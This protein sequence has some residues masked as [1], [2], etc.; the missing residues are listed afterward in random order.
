MAIDSPLAAARQRAIVQTNKHSH[1]RIALEPRILFDGAAIATAVAQLFPAPAEHANDAQSTDADKPA[2]DSHAAAPNEGTAPE[3]S[4]HPALADASAETTPDAAPDAASHAGGSF[5]FID[6]TLAHRADLIAAAPAGAQVVLIDPASNGLAQIDAALA[7]HDNVAAIHIISHGSSGELQIGSTTLNTAAI[8]ADDQHLLAA[9]GQHL[10]PGADVLVYG[11]DFGAGEEGAAATEALAHALH[12]DVAS[13][14]DATGASHLGGDW[15]LERH[16]GAIQ[17]QAIDAAGWDG[18]FLNHAPVAVADTALVNA[19]ISSTINVLA[20]DTDVDGDALTVTTA[21]AMHGTVVINGNG[22]LTYTPTA[23]YQGVDT[24]TYTIKD[25]NNAAALL[26]GTVAVTVNAAP[27]LTLPTLS[28]FNEDVSKVF[29]SALGTQISVSDADGSIARVSLSVPNGTLSLSQTTGLA[30]TLGTGSN[31]SAV[32]FQG[33]ITNVNAALNGMVFAPGAD[34]NGSMSLSASVTDNIVLTAVS[35]TVA[36]SVTAVAD[37]VADSVAT[38][39]GQNVSFNVLTNDTFEN[40]GRVVSSVGTASHGTVS[41]SAQ[42]AA[43]YTPTAGY[44]GTDSFTYTVTTNGTT[45]TATVTVTISPPA[46]NA[47]TASTISNV[48]ASDAQAVSINVSSAFSDADAD[49][50]SYSAT[51]LPSGVS[52]NASTGVISGTLGGHASTAVAGG[53][54]TVVVTANDGRGGTVNQSFHLVV[55]DPAPIANADSGSVVTGS[56]LTGNVLTNDTDPDGDSLSILTTPVVMPSHG[57]LVLSVN[58]NYSYTPTLNYTGTDSFTYRVTDVDGG[59]S[60]AVVSLVISAANHAPVAV[61]DTAFVNA[62]GSVVINVLANDTDADG[63]ALTVTSASALH[64]TVAINGNGTLL[65]TPTASYSGADVI[66][67]AIQDAYGL[68]AGLSGTVAVTVNASA[69]ISLPS[70]PVFYEDVPLIFASAYGTQITVGDVDGNIARVTLSVPVGNLTLSQTTGLTLSQGTGTNDST[71]TLQGSIANVNTALNGL[72]YTPGADY[73]GAVTITLGLTDTLMAVPVTTSL[74]LTI[75]AVADI[76]GDSVSTTLGQSITFNVL[77]NDT[78]ENSGRVV[79]GYT[80]PS[81]GSVS[82]N[83]QGQASYTPTT[84]YTGTDAF[85]YTVTSNGTTE[86]ATVSITIGAAPNQAP[87]ASTI[88]SVAANDAQAV[89]INVSGAFNDADG[90]SLSFSATGL[91]SGLSINASTGV[92]TGTLSG[93]AST[94]VAGGDYTVI[95][96]ASDGRGGSVSQSF[97]LVAA[98]PGPVANA[99]SAAGINTAVLYGNVLTN[100]TDADGDTLT[101][102]TTP[103]VAPAHGSVVISANG[104]YSYTPTLNYTGTDSFTYRVTDADGGTATGTVSIV[105]TAP[106]NQLPTAVADTAFVNAGSSVIINVLANDTD[107]D[108]EALSITH[109]SAAHG[110]VTTNPDGTLTYTPTVGY[111]GT[112]V[113]TYGIQDPRGGNALVDGSVAVTINAL[114]TLHLPTL[115]VL[116]EDTPI[117]FA[118]VLGTQITVGDIDGSVAEVTLSVPAGRLTLSQTTGLSFS[119]GTGTNDTTVTFL[120][121]IVNVNAALNGLVYTPGADYNGP[122]TLTISLTDTLLVIPIT[123]QLPLNITAVVDIVADSVATTTGQLVAFNVLAN[124]N[125]E[126]SG[127]VVSGYTTPSHG[128]VT[129]T[130]QGAASYTPTSGYT[131]TDSFTYT[132]TSNSTTET[133]TVTIV[134]GTP[135][136]NAPTA[137]TL[138]N[139]AASDAQTIS[140]AT[141]STFSDADGDALAYSASGLPTGLSIHAATGVI[142]GQIDGHASTVNGGAYT[143]VVTA[144]DGRGGSVSRSFVINVSNPAPTATDDSATLAEDGS[145]SGNILTND[146]DADG[147]ALSV[148]TTP[149]V[150]PAHG[151]LT[152]NANG[153]YV[154]TPHANFFGSDSFTYRVTD[155]DGASATAVVYLTVTAINDAPTSTAIADRSNTVGS[156]V[157]VNEASAFSDVDGDA[158]VY[159][160]TGLPTGLSVNASTGLI[161][162]TLL[163]AGSYTVTLRA[164]DTGGLTTTQSFHWTVAAAPNNAPN[165]VGSLSPSSANDGAAV[166]IATATAFSDPDGDPLSFSA[167]GLPAGLSINAVTGLISGT[168]NGH[169]S[170]AV[171]GGVYTVVVTANDARGGTVAQVF[172]FT[173]SNPAPTAVADGGAGVEDAVIAGNV[174]T[175]DSDADGDALAV[176]TAPLTAP[177]HG[178]VVLSANG[179]FTYTP[180]SNYSGSDSFTYQV[181]DAD[182]GTSTATVTLT[183]AAVNDAPT[184]TALVDRS[185]TVGAS[186]SVSPSA[187]FIDVDGDALIFT[188]T[189]LPPGLTV[190]ASTGVISGTLRTVGSYSVTLTATDS[191]GLSTS[192]SFYWTAAAAPNNGP[193]T[194]GTLSASTGNDG[195]AVAISTSSAFSDPDGDTLTF[196][197]SGLPAGLTINASTGVISGT[198]DGHASTATSGGVY[199]VIVTANDGRGGSASQGF[200]F[201]ASNPGPTASADSAAGIEDNAISGNVLSNDSDADSDALAVSTTPIVAPSH[202]SLVLSANGAFTYTPDPNYSGSDSFTYQVTDADGGTSTATL[203]LTIAAINDAPTSTALVDRSNTVGASV[204]VSPS[205]SFTDVDGDALVYTATGLPPGLTV[206][207]STGVIS[208]TLLTVGSYSVTLTATDSGGLSTSQSFNWTAAAAPNNGPNTVGVLSA[209][210]GNDGAAVAINTSSAFSDPD[211]DTLTFSATGLPAGLSITANTGVISGTVDGHASTATSGGVYTVIVTANDGRGGSASQGFTFTASNPA[212]TASADSAT[213]IEDNAIS[214]NVLSNDSDADGDALAVSTTPVMA[215]LH[216]SVVLSANGAFTYTPDSNYAGS[217]S[218]TYQ[219]TDADGS[220]STATVTLTIASVNDAPASTA[221]VDRSNAVG[222]SVMVNPAASFTDVDGDALVYTATGLPPGLSVNASTGVIS[223]S[224]LNQG[225]YSVTLTATDPGGLNTSQSFN[226]TV[227]AAPNNGPNTVGSLSA[228]AGNDGAAIAIN[229][230]GAF[231]DP[232]GN[233]LSYSAT[234]LP[235]GLTINASTGVI[236]GTVDGHASAAVSGGVYTVIVTAND[237]RGGSASQGFTF[238]ASNPAP[239][240]SADSAAGVEDNALY[241]NVL[242]NDSDS[243]G[244]ALAVSTTP[245][246]APSHGNVVLAANGAFTYTPDSN[247]SGGDSFTYQLTDADGGTSTAT[248]TLTIAAVNDAPTSTAL[249]DRSNT[250]GASVSLSSSASFTDVDGDALV[251]TA[252]G[253]PPGLTVNASTGVISGTLLTVG[254]YSVTLTATD[255]GGLSTSQSFNWTAAAA[256]NNGPNTAGTL[257]ASAGND[258]AAIAIS[259]SSA[260]SDPDGDTLSYSATGL[261]AGLTIN[262]STGVISG[263]LDG[264]ASAAVSGGVYTVIVTANDGRGGSASQGFTFTASNPGPTALADSAA[265]IEDNAISGNVLSN[266]SD[267]DG[268]ALAVSTTPVMAPSHGN[269]VLAANGA[270]TYTPDSNYSGSDSFTYQLTDTDGGTSTATVTLTIAA[271]N[272]A[273]SS[274]ALADRSNAVGASVSVNLAASFSDVDGDALVYTATGLPPGLTVNA[275]TGVISGTLL[276]VGSYTVTL[277]ATD[278]GG[279]GTA[280][281]FNWAAAAVSNNGPNTVGS[282]APSSS[283]DGAT[284]TISTSS[285]FSDPDGDMLTFSA[286]GLPAGLTINASTGVISGALDRHASAAVSGGVYTVIV[287]ANDGRGGSA[288]QGFT[289]TASNP[290]PTASADTAAGIEDNAVSGNVLSNDSDADG[291]AVAVSTAPLTAPAHGSVVLSANGAFT[292]TPDSNYSGSDSFTYQ[293]TDADGGTSTATV[294]LTIAA[295][296]DAPTSTALV[297]RSNTVGASVSLSSSASFTDVDGDALV[298]TATGLPPGLTVNSS[299]GVISG[300]LLTVGSYSVTLTATDPAGLSTSQSFNWTAAAAPNNGPNTVGTLSASTGNDS[301]AVAIGTSSGFTDPDGDTLTF[302]ASGLPAGLSIN[303]STG[304]ISGTVD[305]HAA[306]AVSGGVYTVVVMANDGRGGSASQGFTFTA[307]NPA[308]SAPADSAT[309]IEDNAISGNVL[310]NDSDADGDVLAVSTTPVVAPLHGSVVLSANGAFTYTPDSNYSGSDLFTYQVTD[311][312]GGTSTATVTLTIAAI[313]DAPTSTALVDRSNTVGASVSLSLSSSFTDVDGDAM[314]YTA[315]GLPPGLTVNASTGLISGSLLTVGSYSVTLTA[316]DSGGSSTSQTFN[317]T[318]AAAPNNGPNTVGTL[319]AGTGNDGAAIAINA[320]GAFSDPDGDTLS[321]SATGLPAGLTINAST[322]V[323]SGTLDGHASAA[324]S[325]G[326]YTVIVTANDGRGGSASQ[327]FTFTASNPGPTASADTASGIEDNT[328]SGNVLSNDSDS[329]GDALA[330]SSTPVVAPLHGKVVL[331]ANGAFTYTPDPNYSGSDSFT[332]QVTDADGGT[333]TATVTLTIAAVNDAPTSTALADRSN[334]VGASVSLSSSASFTDVDGDAL[335]YTATGL[336]PGLTVNASTGVISGTLLTVGSYSVTLTATDSGGLSTSQSFNWTAAAAPN[337]GPNTVGSLTAS[338]GN[339]GDT[340]AISTSGAFSDPDGDTLT[341]SATGLPAGLTINASTGVISG[342]VGGHASNATSGGVYTVIVTANDGRGGSASQGFTFTAS[343]PAPTASADSAAGIEDNAISGNVL[344][345]DSDSDGDA[346]A[347]STTPVMAPSHGNV[348]LAANGAFTYTPDSNY[349]G[350][351]SFTYQLTDADGGTST[352]TVTLTIAAVNDAPT[353]IALSDRSNTVGASVTVSPSASFTDVDGDALIYT[354]TGLPPGLTVN[355]TTGVISGTLLTVGSYSVT[356]T[357]TDSSGLATSETFHWTSSAASNNGPNTVGS[358]SAS[359]GNDGA[360]VTINTSGAFSDPDGDALTFS[361]TGLPAGLA[362]NASTGVISGTVDGHASVSASGGAY[363]VIVTA[364]DGRGGSAAQGFTFTA[365]NPA[366][367]AF[368]DSASGMEDNAISGNALANDSDA[369]SDGFAVSTTPVAAPA[370]GSVV[371]S[372]NGTFTYTPDPNYSGNDSFTYQVTDTDGGTSTAT[373]TLTIAAVNDAPTSS[374]LADRSNAVGASVTVNPAA[375]FTDVDGDALTYA[376]TGLPPGLSVNASTGVISGTLLNQGSYSVTLTATDSNGLSTSQS[377]N[378]TAAATP[379]N[380][381][382]TVG[383]LSASTGNDGAAVTV[384]AS[385]AFSDP[386]GDT[387]TFSATGL[388]AGL[389]I[390]ASTGVISGTVDGHASNAVSGGVYTVI[391]TA[392]D[393][394]G[395]SASQGFTFTASNPAPTASADSAAG[396]EDNALYGNALSNDSD[397]DGDALAVSTAP[398]TAPSHGSVVLS[399]NGAFTYTPDSNYSGSDSFTYQVTDADGGTSTATVTLTIAAVNDA[400]TSSALADRSNA[401]GASVTVNPAAAFTDVDGDALTYA[402]TGLPP[403]LSINALTGVISGTLL[404]QGSY[405]VTLTATDSNGLSTS[406]SF[407]WTAAA[408]PNNGPNTVGSL[409]ASTGNDG[410]AVTV[411]ASGAF[412]DL[413]GDTLT[414]SATG[415]PAGLTIDASTGVISGTVGGHASNAT[416]GGVYTVI[417]TAND[418]RGGS[419]SQGFTFTA[420][421]PAPTASADSAAGIEDN[422]LS[423]NVLS[424][425]SDADGDALAVSTTPVMAPSHGS[426]VLNANGAFTYAPD[427]NYAGSDSFT[428]QVT[429]ADGSTSTATVTLTIAA[430]NDA[431]T[432]IALNDRSNAVGASVSVNPSASLTDVDGDALIYTATGLPPGLTLDASTGVISGTL[433]NQGSYSVTLTATDPSGLSTSQSF[434]WTAAAL[435]NNG[436]NTVEPLSAS[437]GNDGAAVAISTSSAFSDPDGDTLTFSATG[438]PA[439][440]TINASTGV[441]SGTVDGRASAS[442]AGGG[443]TVIVTAND[444]RG[445]SASQGFTFTASNPAPTASADSAGGIENNAISGNVLSNDSDPDADAL[446]VSTTPT[447]SPAHGSVVLSANGAFTYTPDSNYSGSDSFTYQVTDADGGTSTARVTLTIAAVNDAPTSTALVDRINTVGAS[448]TVNPSPSFTDVDGDALVY[449]ATGLPPGLTVNASTGVISGSVLN[450]GS[451]SVTLTATDPGGLSTSQSFNWTTAAAPNTGPITVGSLSA[452]TANDGDAVTINTSAAFSAVDGE[453]LTYSATGLPAGLTIDAITGVISGTVD[454]HASAAASG[455][456]YTVLV[457]ADDMRGGSSVQGFA[458]TATNPVP[459]AVDQAAT[460]TAGDNASGRLLDGASDPDG[461]SL[462]TATTP[463]AAPA[464]GSLV[465]QPDGS[466]SY[467]PAAGFVGVDSFSYLVVDADGATVLATVT[468]TVLPPATVVVTPP[469]VELVD[470]PVT[471]NPIASD[472]PQAASAYTASATVSNLTT[473]TQLESRALAYDIVLLDAVNAVKRLDGMGELKGDAPLLAAV[474]ALRELGGRSELTAGASPIGQLVGDMSGQF[475][476]PIDVDDMRHSS[477]GNSLRDSDEISSVGTAKPGLSD[478]GRDI[479]PALLSPEPPASLPPSSELS[480]Q[481]PRHQ[482]TRSLDTALSS[483]AYRPTTLTEQLRAAS[484]KGHEELDALAEALS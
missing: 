298:Y 290:A 347:V 37:I 127:R 253:L 71:V 358:L 420:S 51:G 87:T 251:Y 333:S 316:T 271:V 142:S 299:T 245:V 188:A 133:T 317:W 119:Q 319:S 220:T 409:S 396:I 376:A 302:S 18:L 320:S 399:A 467:T 447:V 155:A 47:P 171:S 29:S 419:V 418:G 66:T 328:I 93:H 391:V 423:G 178:S 219:V 339:D 275:S 60:T 312:D 338:A 439:G 382:N 24:I 277:T 270:F 281:S 162:G 392:N 279:L 341:F 76:V 352:A 6:Q 89:N 117:V 473:Q 242:S 249:V 215:P 452:S 108:G 400:P 368:A 334:T 59:T 208:G 64:G 426:V 475:K 194:V 110:T 10:A 97:H 39:T 185:N 366:P 389:S 128:T 365:S 173:A 440:L 412:S 77:T 23:S 453:T 144:S 472:D 445:G 137:S 186:V 344:S 211:G 296:N 13:S 260:F 462:T 247:Y 209:S 241:G 63:D 267:S 466:Y 367:I 153:S 78:F 226:W 191:G 350:G 375:S 323:I 3:C 359:T 433:L 55:S 79:S 291:D 190:N 197:A 183:I 177:A 244:D 41:I 52:I 207:A 105:V 165:T 345:N 212:P 278:P 336:P 413:D 131:G 373:V 27:T 7:T 158:L 237:G 68:H 17:T 289:F 254:S 160:A 370:H 297:D 301:A 384:N 434:N 111:S 216:G 175:N 465:I 109:A 5:V 451:H 346:L 402:A 48:A 450:Q 152:L 318:A 83:A 143:V 67:Y 246:M 113:I 263:T 98:N 266:D 385:G 129:V 283:N 8:T 463:V 441:V 62:N 285:A 192:Q 280:Q 115:G 461:D 157:S 65:Y 148:S 92:V 243:D 261:P 126:N 36:M 273:P 180:D 300:T 424:N 136:N 121:S 436:P 321:Y 435:P 120:G 394:R 166:A 306:T 269:V 469:P 294:T 274:T 481:A 134:I 56:V 228:S 31:D 40:S 364:N 360:A 42:G 446:A 310:S 403:G 314:V 390:N 118:S 282:L 230:S 480:S 164:T 428:Y 205:A 100:D 54:Y 86:T 354:A 12:A 38:T 408:T 22:T 231:S 276:T 221:L 349:S 122:V 369:D 53:D 82:I 85:A 240:A 147:D 343:N 286:N 102:S 430:V 198:V 252:T 288:S 431:P 90:D 103:V 476:T 58:G 264:H 32:T 293:V 70:I 161:S 383:S 470:T 414:F 170:A 326:V 387:L 474:G 57:V 443:Y 218:F 405:S 99:D 429:D 305:G 427:S 234:G 377:F 401:V 9:I 483:S 464:H 361:A 169:A 355:A 327:G 284:V 268:D 425:D 11:C 182:G 88:G 28:A 179:A 21:S 202:G 34:F 262:A 362:I 442:V 176:S 459:I 325:G 259:T 324:V 477:F 107:A 172:I 398:L 248:V 484:L 73:N 295:V 114:A 91:P 81:H 112:D 482:L 410:A 174:M 43:S 149:V 235:A 140:I 303:A 150:A 189:G 2:D 30:F 204:S 471:A 315:T 193:N 444:G 135:P 139:V 449:T 395:G 386:D 340:V 14:D 272:D 199:T 200:T 342:T 406:Q 159:T 374:A 330:V 35:G 416:S 229:A 478:A 214:G 353:S 422:A 379:N 227:A 322:G 437:A 123:T 20:N 15:D 104:A 96:T 456:A 378:W 357:A 26:A 132:V 46:N 217:D 101:V 404:N 411:N 457:M 125:F 210:T 141:A 292:Y 307:T 225:S 337:N 331:S 356:L 80:T 329:D 351:D 454:S 201:T 258:G 195:A 265:G 223:G 69:T 213:G 95:V 313:N 233:T 257:S 138:A 181:T 421:N 44:T 1:L 19:N 460:L 256:L 84:G 61:A 415:L 45:E 72:I 458:F 163:A 4:S 187:S 455:G 335:V 407:N 388:P 196:S 309:G 438:L 75:A 348:V 25:S 232:D 448:V 380:G 372:A 397:A 130:A 124:D 332:Y 184:S 206:N 49:T 224:L 154:Y 33:S 116:Y 145:A 255:P 238:T 50:L 168:V 236:S 363:T 167:T 479:S 106:L 287:T 239:T 417:V 156:S 74:P 371:L 432:S 311:A 381:P 393:G 468:L 146:S 16:V 250:V 304:V 222:A 151:N 308:P 203:T 94:A